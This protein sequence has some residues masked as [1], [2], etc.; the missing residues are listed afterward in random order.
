[1]LGREAEMPLLA[2]QPGNLDL[3]AQPLGGSVSFFVQW[4]R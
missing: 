3:L 4:N 2:V 1:M